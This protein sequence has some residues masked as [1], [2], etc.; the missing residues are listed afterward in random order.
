MVLLFLFLFLCYVL[1][2]LSV[3]VWLLLF[4]FCS[5]YF[6][7][8]LCVLVLQSFKYVFFPIFILIGLIL[9]VLNE[10]VEH[11][12]KEKAVMTGA[13]RGLSLTRLDQKAE[14]PY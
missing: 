10:T 5:C 2:F 3:L 8:L 9:R 14:A 11:N 1:Y 4:L 13:S 6:S 7:V 12:L